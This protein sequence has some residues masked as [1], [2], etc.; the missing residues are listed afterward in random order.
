MYGLKQAAILAYNLL[1]KHLQK[2]EYEPVIGTMAIFQHATRRTKFCLCVDGFGVKYYS[3]DDLEH[4]LMALKSKYTITTDLRGEHF[5][6]LTFNWNYEQQYVDISMPQYI[7]NMLQWL[8]HTPPNS[9][10]YSPH[11][12]NTIKYTKAGTTQ[13][14]INE[15][16]SPFASKKDTT[17]VQSVVGSCLYY[18]RAIDGS[19]LPALNEISTTQAQPTMNT[20]RKCRRDLDYLYSHKKA[21]IR[22][23]S[24]AISAPNFRE[25]K[26]TILTGC[27]IFEKIQEIN[28]IIIIF[29]K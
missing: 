9:P 19:I 22:Y 11:E 20:L 16:T 5:C 17:W 2:Y 25:S 15:D 7:G 12:C 29:Q 10:Q 8:K 18:A 24:S 4:F 27:T 14:A 23:R 21:Y 13:T 1:V 6:G 3:Q 26:I 28:L